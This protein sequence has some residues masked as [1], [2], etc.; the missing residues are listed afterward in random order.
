MFGVF[1]LF[2]KGFIKIG[3]TVYKSLPTIMAV[4]GS[5]GVVGTGVLVAKETPEAIEIIKDGKENDKTVMDR[6][7]TVANV[8]EVYS[9]AISVGS[10]SIGC[11]MGSNTLSN[12]RY[13]TLNRKYG[14]L[15]NNFSDYKKET[16][17]LLGEAGSAAAL[18]AMSKNRKVEDNETYGNVF[19]ER[20][21]NDNR[22]WFYESIGDQWLLLDPIVVFNAHMRI[23]QR[24]ML[25]G[26]ATIDQYYEELG[27][28]LPMT[29]LCDDTTKVWSKDYLIKTR[30]GD[31]SIYIQ[32]PKM[33]GPDGKDDAIGIDFI[34]MP[35]ID[36]FLNV[37]HK[38]PSKHKSYRR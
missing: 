35:T 8:V 10:A 38:I 15:A 6:L 24:V 21:E 14:E 7:N 1:S 34:T 13:N 5:V 11:I 29:L 4:A 33:V 32:Y 31:Y 26:L 27:V 3:L 17:K 37:S 22:R 16:T 19:C 20:K 30:N 23:Q 36:P 12:N 18:T 25:H 28:D 9:P 2:A